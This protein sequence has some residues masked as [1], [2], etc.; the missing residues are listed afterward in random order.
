MNAGEKAN[1]CT[2]APGSGLH[3]ACCRAPAPHLGGLMA[4]REIP[5]SVRDMAKS[6]GCTTDGMGLER[7]PLEQWW[8]VMTQ[9]S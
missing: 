1:G 6:R 5:Q 8:V 7:R 4:L 9:D 3:V 2:I